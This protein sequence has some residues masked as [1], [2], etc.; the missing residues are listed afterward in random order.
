MK[1]ELPMSF[2]PNADDMKVIRALKKT[3]GVGFTQ[4]VRIAIRRLA[5]EQKVA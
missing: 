3:M 4:L 1:Q 2:K 5:Q